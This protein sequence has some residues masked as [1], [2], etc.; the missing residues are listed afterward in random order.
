[1]KYYLI[2]LLLLIGT[3]Q[4]QSQSDGVGINTDTV[5]P[6][7]VLQIDATDRGTRWPT[8]TT[9]QRNTIANP[10]TGLWIYN[11][12]TQSFEFYDGSGWRSL[13]GEWTESGSSLKYT[14]SVHLGTGS[15]ATRLEVSDGTTRVTG[16]IRVDGV[17][18]S[19]YPAFSAVQSCPGTGF[20]GNCTA[21][22]DRV[23]IEFP[24]S[25]SLSNTSNQA[26]FTPTMGS[27]DL[28]FANDYAPS[29]YTAILAHGT[30]YHAGYAY[31]P[32]PPNGPWWVATA[33]GDFL[34]TNQGS[35]PFYMNVVLIDNQFIDSQTINF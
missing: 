13:N 11:S 12:T 1:M 32:T 22:F 35:Q 20:P 14:N 19:H 27:F 2:S 29:N 6:K 23:M 3:S 8:F 4:I 10:A 28:G 25:R 30:G 16:N 33:I 9:A 15:P 5:D 21:G 31:Q 7:A 24:L 17:V 34:R 26:T 18:A